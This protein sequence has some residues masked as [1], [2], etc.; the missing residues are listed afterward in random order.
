MKIRRNLSRHQT[1]YVQNLYQLK[2]IRIIYLIQSDLMNYVKKLERRKP[3]ILQALLPLI[4]NVRGKSQVF[5]SFPILNYIFT[6][7]ID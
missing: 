4:E 6:F 2:L 7:C 1:D 3:E 5:S